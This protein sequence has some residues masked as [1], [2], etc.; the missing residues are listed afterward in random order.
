MRFASRLGATLPIAVSRARRRLRARAW[1]LL[2]VSAML[3]WLGVLAYPPL[4]LPLAEA[5][6]AKPERATPKPRIVETGHATTLPVSFRDHVKPILDRRCVVCHGCYDAPCQL[7]LSAIEGIDRGATKQKLYDNGRLISV[8]PTRLF[9]DHETTEEWRANGFFPVLNERAESSEEAELAYSLLAQ[10]VALKRAHP[11]P[12][13]PPNGKI[14]RGFEFALD[15]ELHCPTLEEFPRFAKTHSLWGMPYALPGLTQKEEAILTTWI[16]DGARVEPHPEL[17]NALQRAVGEWESF[18]NGDS[19]KARLVARYLYEHWFIGHVYFSDVAGGDTVFFRVVRS[20]TPPGESLREIASTRPFDDPG[21]ARVY[22]R[23]RRVVNTLTDKNHFAYALNDARKKRLRELFFAPD[24]TVTNLPSYDLQRASNPFKTFQDLPLE[25]RY[26]FLLDDAEYFFS[27]FIKGP[28]CRGQ[29][30]VNVIQSQF[31]VAFMQ[32]RSS[33][34][35]RTAAFLA[36]N[37]DLLD[38]PAA[39]GDDIGALGWQRYDELEQI[40]RRK[41]DEF[42]NQ[43]LY[44]EGG[45]NVDDI[46]DGDGH[47]PNAALTVFRHYDRATVVQGFVGDTPLTGWVVDYPLFERIHYLLVAGFNVFG[48]TWH[49]IATRKYMDYLRR[50]AEDNFLRFLPKHYRLIQHQAWYRG[51]GPEILGLDQA[52]FSAEYETAVPFVTTNYKSELFDHFRARLGAAAG[53]EDVINR[54]RRETC[55]RDNITA[56]QR[57]L[58]DKLRRLAQIKGL[59]LKALPETAFLRIETPHHPDGGWVY[60]LVR[61][62][63]LSNV[64]FFF[65]ETLRREPHYD[66]LAVIPGFLGSYPNLFFNVKAEDLDAFIENLEKA[67]TTERIERFYQRFAIRRT[68]PDFW[69]YADWFNDQHQKM[70][71]VRAGLFDLNRYQAEP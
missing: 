23:L 69:F 3:A 52:L 28:V 18:L 38:L 57:A 61:N 56:A 66:S 31:W 53:P 51:M 40:F 14:P 37:S 26:R 70:D 35:A 41:Q 65:A 27:G 34:M 6:I 13:E 71:G 36:E 32:P 8:S 59:R 1:P 2:F 60:T 7:D 42:I 17:S 43:A 44:R 5:F 58:E 11:M 39:S 68:H 63:A 54:C 50:E 4:S 62:D 25:A 45:L 64:A 30:A 9:I 29:V 19:L 20:T 46:W 15:R 67:T 22:Y 33:F 48:S 10:T 47:N 12:L 49:Q 24:Y 55:Q 16:K 21:V